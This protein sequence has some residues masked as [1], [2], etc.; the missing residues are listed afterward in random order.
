MTSAVDTR[1]EY[2]ATHLPHV[3]RRGLA[4]G[5]FTSVVVVLLSFITR[6]TAPPIETLLG[7][8]VLLVG[9]VGVTALPGRWT[10]AR[11]IEGVAGAAGI[12]LLATVVFMLVDVALLQ[13]LGMWTNRWREIGGGSNWWYHPVWWMAGTLL[14]WLGALIL[15]NRAAR[16]RSASF[17]GVM[18]PVLMAAVA[19]AVVAVLVK[20]PGA[21]WNL[22]TFGVAFL[23][24][25]IIA[26]FLSAMGRVR[27]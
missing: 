1:R 8:I 6:F 10:G 17:A 20:F 23:P 15:A 3:L 7:G 2:D 19:C 5:L 12:G 9:L 27:P 22:S 4:L 11:T 24:G 21:G 14:P 25:L 26:A 13:P 18:L 16:G